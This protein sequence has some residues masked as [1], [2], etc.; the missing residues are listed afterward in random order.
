MLKLNPSDLEQQVGIEL[1]S[2]QSDEE[3]P[4]NNVKPKGLGKNFSVPV[5]EQEIKDR[6]KAF[7][8]PE[9]TEEVEEVEEVKATPQ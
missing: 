9:S 4:Q 6:N 7:E 5:T 3:T 2:H 8:S 1:D